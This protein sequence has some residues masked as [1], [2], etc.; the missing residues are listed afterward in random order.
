[1]LLS[2]HQKFSR[3]PQLR[4]SNQHRRISLLPILSKTIYRLEQLGSFQRRRDLISQAEGSVKCDLI[5]I[6][7]NGLTATRKEAKRNQIIWSWRKEFNTAAFWAQYCSPRMSKRNTQS[8]VR[9]TTPKRASLILI[10]LKAYF[11]KN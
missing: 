7:I 4:P 10:Q 9:N 3:W 6:P 11:I 2:R 1:M 8:C 5:S